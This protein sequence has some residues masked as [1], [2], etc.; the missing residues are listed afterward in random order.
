M[1]EGRSDQNGRLGRRGAIRLMAGTAAVAAGSVALAACG[2][3]AVPG[4]V[5]T[6]GGGTVDAT[7]AKETNAQSMVSNQ[8][9]T[10]SLVA[11]GKD[12]FKAGDDF[13]YYF[14]QATGDGKWSCQINKQGSDSSDKG[15]A[16]AGIVARASGDPGAPEVAVLLTDG[17]G[18]TFRW[19]KNQ[20]DQAESWPMAIAIGVTAPLWL[21]L[22][23]Q[24]DT[25]TVSYSTDGKSWQNPTTYQ[26]AFP[27]Q[28]YLIGLAACSHS[29]KQAVD[30]FTNL[31]QGF[32]PSM[33]LDI[34]PANASSS[35][36]SK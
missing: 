36:S 34:N 19:R 23:K 12:I 33:Y 30:V 2:G 27:S 8:N 17:N 20:G 28:T 25:W 3:A 5:H 16:L 22:Q 32:K 1:L 9:G 10:I 21:Q 24:G 6:M 31:S 29:S 7:A 26:V 11:R 4:A 14:Q 18:V 13:T 15:N 35:S